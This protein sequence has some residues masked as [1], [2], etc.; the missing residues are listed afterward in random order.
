MKWNAEI[1]DFVPKMCQKCETV[2]TSIRAD[3]YLLKDIVAIRCGNCG[4]VLLKVDGGWYT[5]M[6]GENYGNQA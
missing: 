3:R 6:V 2:V 1:L 5:Q 4:F